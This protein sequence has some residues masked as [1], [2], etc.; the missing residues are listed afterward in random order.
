MIDVLIADDQDLVRAG[1]AMVVDAAP[2]MRVV[3]TAAT[4]AEAIDLAAR[5]HPDVILM[6]IRMP[7]T[8]GITATKAILG[9]GGRPPKILAL[10]TYDSNDYATRILD[11]GASGYLLKDTTAEGLTAAVRSAYHGGSV[12]APTTTR[13]L[14]AARADPPVPR[15]PAPLDTFTTRERDVFDLIVAG[16]NNAEIAQRLHLAE[17][18]VKTHVGRVLAK[19]GVRDR[20]NVVV[21]AYRN[22]AAR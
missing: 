9:A 2:D 19:L 3:A 1:F 5:H 4:G 8:D 12:I 11:A 14:V 10:T 22:G 6:D 13:N 16:A 7:G 20:L 17:V 15:D 18:T 21:W